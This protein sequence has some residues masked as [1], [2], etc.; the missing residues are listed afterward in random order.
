MDCSF[1][2]AD[3]K[4]YN[5]SPLTLG[6]FRRF[7]LWVQYRDYD[8]FLTLKEKLTPEDFAVESKRILSECSAKRL[9]ESS[10]E[11]QAAFATLEGVTYLLYLSLKRNH[12]TITA[13]DVGDVLTM[14]TANEAGD[15]LAVLSGIPDIGKKNNPAE[16]T[17]T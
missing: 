9:T 1:Q 12:P 10:Q 8:N 5:L 2:G 16:P 14:T 7:T 13:V 6:D 17:L 4:H 15:K 11:V 3:N